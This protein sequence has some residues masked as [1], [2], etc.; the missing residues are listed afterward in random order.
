M[1]QLS[2]T[3]RGHEQDVRDVVAMGP[4]VASVSRDGTLRV[5]QRRESW[6][7]TVMYQAGGFLNSVCYDDVEEVLYCGGKDSLINGVDVAAMTAVAEPVAEPVYTLVGH[8][9]N[10]CSLRWSDGYVLSGS[11][12]KTGRVWA[13]NE[14]RY[15]L[16]GHTAS[17]WDV[18]RF[19]EHT[20]LTAGADGAIGVWEHGKLARMLTGIHTD[21]VRHLEVVDSETF[22]SCSNDGTVKISDLHGKVR[23]TMEGHESF[24]YYIRKLK[25]G[26]VSC[27]EDRS[28][29]VWDANGD[30]KQVIRIPAIS[31]WCVDVMENGDIVV[32]SS[33]NNLRIFTENESRIASDEEI[34]EFRQEIESSAINPQTMDFDESK[35]SPF[36]TLQSPGKKEG[37]VVVVKTPQGVIEAHQYSN[38]QWMKV[39]DVVGSSTA[40]N[41]KKTEYEGKMYDYVFDVDIEEG[42]PPLKLPVNTTDNPYLVA[43]KFITKYELPDSYKD[44]IVN[45]IIKNTSGMSLDNTSVPPQAPQETAPPTNHS[46]S[47]NMK[48]LPVKTIL[49]VNSYNPDTLF[50]GV[51]KINDTENT[52]NDEDLALIGTGLHSLQESWEVLYNYA[53]KM[54]NTWNNKTPAFDIMRLIVEF[55]PDADNISE[56]IEHG[57]G[58]KDITITMLTVRILINSFGNKIWGKELLGSP[59]VYENVFETI[60]T[61]YPSATQKKSQTLAIAVSTLLYNY[62]VMAITDPNGANILPSIADNINNKFAPLEEYQTSEE[63]AYRLLV[64]FGNLATIEPTLKQ[65]A[66]SLSWIKFVKVTFGHADRF[67][68]VLADLGL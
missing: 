37:Q 19:N 59:K 10:V 22:A 60:D 18:L 39:G 57:M 17:V 50:N 38:G 16:K 13:Q 6:E 43:D 45:F 28:V 56:F 1:Y 63:A 5:W 9:G 15:E 20:V 44:Q 55:L 47:S 53:T 36:E 23:K 40:G 14:V 12:D 41:D 66:P 35:L 51:A 24:V 33:D 32:G 46:T 4:R 68:A 64:A 61:M 8:S 54:L 25:D 67:N 58:N 30:V 21:V 42:Q 3:L 48:V 65:F 62:S 11:W 2:A 27:G 7:S 52:L 29:R 26:L 49:Q 34:K 31:V